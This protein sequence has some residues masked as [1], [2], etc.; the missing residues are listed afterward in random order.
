VDST[1]TSSSP[2]ATSTLGLPVFTT[3]QKQMRGNHTAG[4]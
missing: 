2:L 4:I 1:W 3:K